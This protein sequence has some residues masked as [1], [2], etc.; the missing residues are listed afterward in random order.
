MGMDHNTDSPTYSPNDQRMSLNMR[1][2]R[3]DGRPEHQAPAPS[4]RNCGLDL[5][6]T[7]CVFFV[8]VTHGPGSG[9]RYADWNVF[10]ANLWVL[11]F[12]TLLSSML[13]A[14]SRSALGPYLARLGALFLFGVALNAAAVK[15]RG[16]N[17]LDFD[18][19]GPSR[20][21]AADNELVLQMGY[22]LCIQAF[23]ALFYTMR[24]IARCG[25]RS[26]AAFCTATSVG[27]IAV[28]A[29]LDLT[30]WS[31]LLRCVVAICS[32]GYII[33]AGVAGEV[34]QKSAFAAVLSAL[35]FV[36]SLEASG[37]NEYHHED[38][39]VGPKGCNMLTFY[40][41]GFSWGLVKDHVDMQAP[42]RLLFTYWPL[43][44]PWLLY[45]CVPLRVDLQ[46]PK[47][48]WERLAVLT[49]WIT[50]ALGFLVYSDIQMEDYLGVAAPL[51]MWSL[52]WYCG[53]M[54]FGSLLGSPGYYFVLSFSPYVVI[55]FGLRRTLLTRRSSSPVE[56]TP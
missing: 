11:Y 33:R 37:W 44:L 21:L 17:V 39:V 23:G 16:G 49:S 1:D 47:D 26:I 51:N 8:C 15:I 40:A 35:T 10:N 6:R 9:E 45:S 41:W 7:I 25:P 55:A 29:A 3:E 53:H 27:L 46:G 56:L 43:A 5:M 22:I 12:L 50:F 2:C 18:H 28:Q 19:I 52:V 14:R 24:G 38:H 34:N 4:Q 36:V 20:F 54:L 31:N 48:P 13:L 30:E 42:R 32:N